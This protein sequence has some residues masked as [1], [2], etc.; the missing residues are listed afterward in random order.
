VCNV[1]LERTTTKLILLQVLSEMQRIMAQDSNTKHVFRELDGFLILMSLLSTIQDKQQSPVVEP[2]E[3]VVL[4][5][6]ENARLI[7]ANLSEAM[8]GHLQNSE[9]FRVS[10]GRPISSALPTAHIQLAQNVVSYDS[11]A[12]AIRG[13]VSNPKTMDETLGLLLSFA[14]NNFELSGIFKSLR[15]TS[16]SIADLDKAMSRFE[17]KLGTIHRPDAILI[18]WNSVQE[19]ASADR[20]LC[21]AVYKLFELLSRTSHRN[22]AMLSSLGLLKDVLRLFSTTRSISTRISSTPSTIPSTPTTVP[23]TPTAASS[24]S[25]SKALIP[26]KERQVLQKLL[27]RL[28]DMGATTTEARTIF[29]KAIREDTG[30]LDS[31]MLDLLRFG[32][33]SRWLEHFSMEGRSALVLEEEGIRGLPAT[34]FTFMVIFHFVYRENN[35]H[36]DIDL[37]AWLY[38]SSVPGSKFA[39]FT[40]QIGDKTLIS[41]SLRQDG[42]LELASTANKEAIMFSRT[43]FHQCRWTH[44]T[45]VHYPHRA[46]NPTIRKL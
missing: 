24:A 18:L 42:T 5:V 46:S 12:D 16:A 41:L 20:T 13:L 9:Y 31:E 45:L 7:F 3:Q 25:G 26:E 39:L 21:Y 6:L 11:L 14:M 8:Q 23:G 29:Q 32:M 34:G 28:L 35:A 27:R 38:I 4:D 37:Q 30:G 10:S 36:T 44:V 15:T 17:P 33:K 2:E 40:F 22:L 43:Q 1:R 19:V